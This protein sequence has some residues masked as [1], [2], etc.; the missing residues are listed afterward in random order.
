MQYIYCVENNGLLTVRI[1]P[2]ENKMLEIDV[3]PDAL[4]GIGDSDD[5]FVFGDAV[6][7]L[8]IEKLPVEDAFIPPVNQRSDIGGVMS[9]FCTGINPFRTVLALDN[10]DLPDS[11]KKEVW[12]YAVKNNAYKEGKGN[13]AVNGMNMAKNI[14]AILYPKV[15]VVYFKT[16]MLSQD[17]IGVMSK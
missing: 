6:S 3:I 8:D 5:D 7:L 11:L 15:P 9:S 17:H 10:H 14:N 2:H 13:Y 1:Y 4:L 16:T 12:D